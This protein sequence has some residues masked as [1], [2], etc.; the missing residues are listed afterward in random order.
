MKGLRTIVAMV[1]TT[2]ALVGMNG[3]CA[4]ATTMGNDDTVIV[5]KSDSEEKKDSLNVENEKNKSD[6]TEQSKLADAKAKLDELNKKA[7]NAGKSDSQPGNNNPKPAKPAAKPGS[8]TTNTEKPTT[9]PETNTQGSDE[10]AVKPEPNTPSSNESGSK[11]EQDTETEKPEM[12]NEPKSN[13]TK[14]EAKSSSVKIVNSNDNAAAS[15]V[16]TGSDT[17][18]KVLGEK[19]VNGTTYYKVGANRWV[20]AE[21][22][23]VVA[24]NGHVSTTKQLPQTG[25]KNEVIAAVSG[26]TIASV[27]IASAM[28]ISRKKKNN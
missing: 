17:A 21:K 3:Y 5:K 8:E 6:S 10:S 1:L 12:K 20:K 9:K 13:K 28:G 2:T 15:V 4:K 11:K 24:V 16:L 7:N 23:H 22:A 14:A 26:L 19:T 25:A 27:G 18:V